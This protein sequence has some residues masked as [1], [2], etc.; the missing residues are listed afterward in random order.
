[1]L[2]VLFIQDQVNRDVPSAWGLQQVTQ[3]F[4]VCKQIHHNCYHLARRKEV[5]GEKKPKRLLKSRGQVNCALNYEFSIQTSWVT[6]SLTTRV[7]TASRSLCLTPLIPPWQIKSLWI[8]MKVPLN[9]Y[10]DI[11]HPATSCLIY[12]SQ[13][14]IA[15][16]VMHM[17]KLWISLIQQVCIA[18][19]KYDRNTAHKQNSWDR[20][21]S[22]F[23]WFEYSIDN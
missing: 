15:E 7:E 21:K 10:E 19:S 18:I 4:H 9:N 3:Y 17:H 23:N 13:K 11:P 12:H 14:E 1:M 5:E 2:Q 20:Q 16:R 22:L 8:T 6:E